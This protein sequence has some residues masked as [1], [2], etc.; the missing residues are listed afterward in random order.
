MTKYNVLNLDGKPHT[1]KVLFAEYE[2]VQTIHGARYVITG[3]YEDITDDILEHLSRLLREARSGGMLEYDGPAGIGKRTSTG[4]KYDM[5][6]V[7]IYVT[8]WKAVSKSYE[9]TRPNY[10]SEKLVAIKK[11]EDSSA[12]YVKR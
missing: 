10:D 12:W 9:Q 5:T 11:I 8:N 2:T 7:N 4:W 1:V 3:K 6:Y